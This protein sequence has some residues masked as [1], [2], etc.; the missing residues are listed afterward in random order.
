MTITC[1]MVPICRGSWTPA[2][3]PGRSAAW[4]RSLPTWPAED[5]GGLKTSSGG[6]TVRGGRPEH[7]STA[8]IRRGASCFGRP[9]LRQSLGAV[10][11][12]HGT[13]PAAW[14]PACSIKIL[15]ESEARLHPLS[16]AESMAPVCFDRRNRKVFASAA[17]I[18]ADGGSQR[19][20]GTL[21]AWMQD[22]R[23]PIFL[24][25]TANNIA[26][27]PP[28]LMRKGRFD[29]IFFV[30]LPGV[31]DRKTIFTIHLRK[32]RRD[33]SQFDLDRLAAASEGFSGAEIEQAVISG[34][35]AA[36]SQDA[37]CTTEHLLAALH[38]T[39]PLSVLMR[40]HIEQLR[41]WA[42]G[43]CVLAD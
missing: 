16:Q 10:V 32:R 36:F 1:W 2:Q 25:A 8:S 35:Y 11:A 19:M 12:R 40:E 13:C 38:T 7:A 24:I 21:L 4:R 42:H 9:G 29:E 3:R 22:H 39:Q 15:G 14:T 23:H 43:R 18:S 26:D 34:L 20:F 31:E 6:S 28:E 33:K 37:E 5:I 30:D 27:L 41:A 17:T